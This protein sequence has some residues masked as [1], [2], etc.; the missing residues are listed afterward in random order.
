[1]PSYAVQLGESLVLVGGVHVGVDRV[2]GKADLGGAVLGVEK[3]GDCIVGPDL[4]A[5]DA[6]QLREAAAFPGIDQI[7]ARRL[8]ARA[9][10]RLHDR[11]LQHAEGG[12]AGGEG[13]D[14][15]LGVRHLAHVLG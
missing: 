1:M 4:L 12:D 10:L 7:M 3:A 15:R 6:K 14:V 5:L 13:F 8:A 11:I 9:D 2:L